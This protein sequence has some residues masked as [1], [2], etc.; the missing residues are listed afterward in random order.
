[1]RTFTIA[2][3]ALATS[4]S[5]AGIARADE[6]ISR[7]NAESAA[8]AAESWQDARQNHVPALGYSAPASGQARQIDSI[9]AR[10]QAQPSADAL[11]LH[12]GDRGLGTN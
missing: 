4:L 10:P 11:F 12:Q 3:L 6:G 5:L 7:E 8:V 1:M 9:F 2:A